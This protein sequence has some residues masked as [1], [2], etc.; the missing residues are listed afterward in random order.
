MLYLQPYL[1]KQ[2]D[3]GPARAKI[4]AEGQRGREGVQRAVA[5]SKVGDEELA[6]SQVRKVLKES[7]DSARCRKAVWEAS[8]G[9]GPVV[10][11]DLKAL[12]LLRYEAARALGFAKTITRCS[13][14]LNEQSSRRRA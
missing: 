8:K 5:W 12:I 11:A 14:R 1:E 13:S 7:K 9:V 4:S 6:D 10:E 3:P 2:V